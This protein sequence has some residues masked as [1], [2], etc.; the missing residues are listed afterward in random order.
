[1]GSI[2][3]RKTKISLPAGSSEPSTAARSH[4]PRSVGRT[5]PGGQGPQTGL[6]RIKR[7]HCTDVQ[8][9]AQRAELGR[10]R[11]TLVI[12]PLVFCRP[13]LLTEGVKEPLAD[14]QGTLPRVTGWAWEG[15]QASA[16]TPPP[17][18]SFLVPSPL[19]SPTTL[20]TKFVPTRCHLCP[21]SQELPAHPGFSPL[22]QR[23]QRGIPGTLLW[24][25]A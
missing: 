3:G 10:P 11:G 1:M 12:A 4:T 25:R 24:T 15:S 8:T 23:P 7:A 5:L 6:S 22:P 17:A 19:A 16:T 18:S 20:P 9:E 14:S 2:P 13:E 21:G